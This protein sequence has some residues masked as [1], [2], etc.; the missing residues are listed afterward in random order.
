MPG[1]PGPGPGPILRETA[2]GELDTPLVRKERTYGAGVILALGWRTTVELGAARTGWTNT[3]PDYLGGSSDV[4]QVLDRTEDGADL[5]A[6][7]RLK[8]RTSLTL[9]A[10]QRDI[11]F[12]N[13]ATLKDSTLH[14][15]LPGLRFEAGG[16]CPDRSSSG[17]PTSTSWPPASPTSTASWDGPTSPTGGDGRR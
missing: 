3:D 14:Q 7:Y 5:R 8:G 6:S 10:L 2:T 13:P 4:G 11:T 1:D 17:R 15:I 16:P 9:E 12:D